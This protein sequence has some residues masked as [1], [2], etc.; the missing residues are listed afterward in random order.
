MT[1][2]D[3]LIALA[4]VALALILYFLPGRFGQVSEGAI[5]TIYVGNGDEPF[6]S[7]PLDEPRTIT[8][9]QGDGRVN[10]IEI[11]DGGV[12]MASSTCLNQS[13]VREG[14]VTNENRRLRVMGD[15]IVC[16]PNGVAIEVSE[17]T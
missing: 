6:E 17:G 14:V 4:A 5:V 12:R 9:D 1:G 13:C 10:V 3:A 11:Y 8:I 2:R 7:V 16:L 15:W